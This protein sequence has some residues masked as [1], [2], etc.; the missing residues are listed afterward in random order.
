MAVFAENITSL[1]SNRVGPMPRSQ[2]QARSFPTK[3]NNT[4]Y[5]SKLSF[6]KSFRFM[7]YLFRETV[8]SYYTS[9]IV[10]YKDGSN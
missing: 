1:L 7:A 2:I 5:S 9:W 8:I 3:S 6:K 10:M 4:A